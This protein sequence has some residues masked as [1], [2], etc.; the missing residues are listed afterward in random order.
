MVGW[1]GRRVLVYE[2]PAG[3]S[4]RAESE[5]ARR[6]AFADLDRMVRMDH[7]P[8]DRRHQ[9]KIDYPALFRRLR[10]IKTD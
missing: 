7:L 2:A 9:A 8:L 4:A 3:E 6:M 5:L 1:S 10:R